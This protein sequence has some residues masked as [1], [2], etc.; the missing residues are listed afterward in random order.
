M[1]L[2]RVGYRENCWLYFDITVNYFGCKL[3]Y[4]SL[5]ICIVN[6]AMFLM[7]SSIFEINAAKIKLAASFH[8]EF[9]LN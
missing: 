9:R 6:N 4:S 8:H 3:I 1:F 5:Q 7:M 2:S